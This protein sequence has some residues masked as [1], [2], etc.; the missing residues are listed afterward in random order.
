[1]GDYHLEKPAADLV[2]YFSQAQGPQLY[3]LTPADARAAVEAGQAEPVPMPN[4]EESWITVSAEIGDVQVLLIRPRGVAEPL[5]VVLYMH[6]GGWIMG[7]VKTHGRLARELAVGA[8]AAVAFVDY[9]LAPEAQYPVQIEQCYAVA[10]W[11]TEHGGDHGLDPARIAVAGDSAGGNMA[12]VLT[13]M[14]KQRGD[15][16]FVHQSMYYPMTD[17]GA[18]TDSYRLFKDGPYGGPEMTAWFWNSYL[19]NEERRTEI[20]ASPLRASRSDLEG[21]P[22]ALVI[23]D[24]NDV[25]RDEGEAYADKLREAGVPTTSVRF[26]GTMHDFLMLDAL[27]D[28][29]STKAAMVLATAAL[30]RAFGA[31]AR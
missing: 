8:G 31:D 2:A 27:R 13:V 23:V 20:T 10:R 26:N 29:E 1:M 30:R 12:T 19:P 7:S 3:E 17:G 18:G 21:L 4:L 14:A 11:A 5:P 16:R 9:S 28:T 25:L 22:P 6:G 24:E 15:V